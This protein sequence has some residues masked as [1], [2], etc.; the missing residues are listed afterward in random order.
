MLPHAPT[1]GD[2]KVSGYRGMVAGGLQASRST[3]LWE[4]HTRLEEAMKGHVLAQSELMGR[5]EKIKK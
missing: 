5:Y 1:P 4:S 3:R 2:L